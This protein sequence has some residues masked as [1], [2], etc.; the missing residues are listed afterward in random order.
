[1]EK[2]YYKLNSRTGTGISASF[3]MGECY[4]DPM[5]FASTHRIVKTA[6][7]SV[8]NSDIKVN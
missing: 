4:I 6:R 8:L 1:M 3:F 5:Q 7:P 2:D